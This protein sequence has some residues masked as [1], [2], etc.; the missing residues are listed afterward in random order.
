MEHTSGH[1][2]VCYLVAGPVENYELLMRGASKIAWTTSTAPLEQVDDGVVG[3]PGHGHPHEPA[4]GL[5]II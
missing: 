5:A 1:F 3:L 2:F 4:Q